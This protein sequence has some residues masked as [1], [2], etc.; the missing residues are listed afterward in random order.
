MFAE[1][2]TKDVLIF[3]CGNILFGDDGFGPAVIE[4]LE[5]TQAVPKYAHAEDVGTSIKA[6]LVDIAFADRRPK[7]I[8]VVDAVD[9]PGRTAG[10]VFEITPD[11]IPANKLA[12]FFAHGFPSSNLLKEL[13]D[14]HGIAV[15][16]VVAQVDRLP[17]KVSQGLS[18]PIRR[19]VPVAARRVLEIVARV[20]G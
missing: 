10:E 13:N 4:E 7:C 14:R 15:R 1:L 19:A 2:Q 18:E 9:K 3:G 6:L 12:D 11:D 8:I 17:T 20:R 16:I 5:N